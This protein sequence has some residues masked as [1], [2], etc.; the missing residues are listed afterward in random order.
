MLVFFS[1]HICLLLRLYK[2]ELRYSLT[3][4][5]LINIL[6]I[7]KVQAAHTISV[8]YKGLQICENDAKNQFESCF[9]DIV[10]L[11]QISQYQLINITDVNTPTDTT[12]LSIP[13]YLLP[14][15]HFLKHKP[16][17]ILDNGFDRGLAKQTCNHLKNKGFT[18]FHFLNGGWPSL[19]RQHKKASSKMNTENSF[20]YIK[21]ITLTPRQVVSELSITSNQDLIK[22][23]LINKNID[24]NEVIGFEDFIVDMSSYYLQDRDN[25]WSIL[26]EMVKSEENIRAVIVCPDDKL[27]ELI[28]ELSNKKPRN[29]FLLDGQLKDLQK[30]T[31]LKRLTI[32]SQ[33]QATNHYVCN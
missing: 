10:P 19:I 4:L 11:D 14:S 28:S 24:K 12:I 9:S 7:G 32:L 29:T 25:F 18:K 15:K 8:D 1:K 5:C 23:L 33:L 13:L 31:L 30:Q 20:S 2:L 17:L 27:S 16:L 3:L 6:I 26:D 22:L 21:H